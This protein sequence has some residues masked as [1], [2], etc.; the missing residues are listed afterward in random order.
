MLDITSDFFFTTFHIMLD[1][2]R[3]FTQFTFLS[4]LRL[5][6]ATL[7]CQNIYHLLCVVSKPTLNASGWLL[8]T[9]VRLSILLGAIDVGLKVPWSADTVSAITLMSWTGDA[10]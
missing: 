4:M 10:T 9:Q 1:S 8:L 5:L 7:A 6:F 3:A 2:C